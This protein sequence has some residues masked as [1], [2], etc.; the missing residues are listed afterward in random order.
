MAD[1]ELRHALALEAARLM[2][3]R[4]EPDFAAAKRMAAN[5]LCR[6]GPKPEDLP[7]NAEVRVQIAA[8]ADA[9]DGVTDP[10]TVFRIFLLALEA[11]KQQPENHPEGDALFHTLQV[12]ELA[13]DARSYDEE[14]LLAALLHDVG[15]A[16]NPDDHIAAGLEALDGMITDRTRFLIENHTRAC[17]YR[18]GELPAKQRDRLKA[19][20]DFDDVLLLSEL[21]RAGRV[22]GAAVGTVDEAI[23]YLRGLERSNG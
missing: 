15:K 9:R 5:R 17:E 7:S 22:P 11:V 13:R 4:V 8:F 16:I 14:F 23:E 10:Y 21:D 6:R 1:Q 19:S 20:P 18:A 3:Q 2:C 12:F